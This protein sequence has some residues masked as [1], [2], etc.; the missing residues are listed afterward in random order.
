[1]DVGATYGAGKWKWAA[2]SVGRPWYAARVEGN[3][4]NLGETSL[5][6]I[7]TARMVS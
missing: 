1:M 5:R 7:W 4:I 3:F 6:A 2:I